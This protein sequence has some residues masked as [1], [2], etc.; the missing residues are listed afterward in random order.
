[1]NYQAILA[2]V[3]YAFIGVIVFG[4][5]FVIVDRLTPYNLWKELVENKN[6]ALAIV[7]GLIGL[8]V[9]IIIA[10]AMTG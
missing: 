10:A 8:G 3:I 7:V 4:L 9:C 5:T 2:S 6:T 1:M